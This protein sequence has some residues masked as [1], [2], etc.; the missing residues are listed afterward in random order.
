[1]CVSVCG[2]GKCFVCICALFCGVV[3]C[4]CVGMHVCLYACHERMSES[5]CACVC[6]GG[7]M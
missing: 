3:Y 6:V 2:G 4:G 1:M 5:A 7:S